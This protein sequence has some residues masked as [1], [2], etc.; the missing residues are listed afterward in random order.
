MIYGDPDKFTQ[1]LTNLVENA[2]RHGEGEVRVST[3]PVGDPFPGVLVTVEDEGE[4]IHPDIRARVFTKFWKHGIRGGSGLGMYIVHGLTQV[5]GGDVRSRTR[6]A[7]GR[8][9]ADPLAQHR[10]RPP[11]EAGSPVLA[12]GF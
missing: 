10:G 8:G 2:L 9:R 3:E 12:G 7:V 11:A 1:V 4:G 5:H 6:P